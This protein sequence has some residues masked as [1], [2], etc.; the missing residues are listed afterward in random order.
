[1]YKEKR[2]KESGF[3]L[4]E[5]MIVILIIG[6]IISI[7]VP[8][9][10][11]TRN[12]SQARSCAK[13]LSQIEYAKEM[14]AMDNQKKNNDIPNTDDLAGYYSISEPK[15]PAGGTYEI[16][17]LNTAPTCSIGGEHKIH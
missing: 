4:I 17:D 10:V 1:M 5:I 12:K 11:Y 14:W 13:Q 2:K 7:A 3:T 6:I 15:C 9:W 16:N 8:A